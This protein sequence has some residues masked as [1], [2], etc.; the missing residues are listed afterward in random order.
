MTKD[1]KSATADKS[2]KGEKKPVKKEITEKVTEAAPEEIKE[3][4]P[5][6]TEKVTETVQD[7]KAEVTEETT[8]TAPE[9]VKE[10]IPEVTE[11]VTETVQDEKAEVTDKVTES[12]QEGKTTKTNYIEL[13]DETLSKL[14]EKKLRKKMQL[15]FET[16]PHVNVFYLTAD[17]TPFYSKEDA[18]KHQK[19]IG[20]EKEVI[21]I[22]R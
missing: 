6:V 8:A 11:E 16:N 20:I 13:M 1:K 21:T 17:E 5:E 15:Y 4:I 14:E 18:R 12:D 19:S 22:N 7:E 3:I 9:E 10:I 2:L